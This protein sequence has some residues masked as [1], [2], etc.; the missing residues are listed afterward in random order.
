MIKK[1]SE[2]EYGYNDSDYDDYSVE[3]YDSKDWGTSD[4][5]EPSLF[6]EGCNGTY[7]HID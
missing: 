1:D 2:E 7:H 3:N 5:N 6:P 4:P